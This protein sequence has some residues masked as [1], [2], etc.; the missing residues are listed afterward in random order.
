VNS[1]S[2]KIANIKSDE[3]F[4]IVEIDVS[5]VSLKSII[6]ETPETVPFLKIGSPMNIMFKETEVS[7]AKD[8]SG[9]LSLQNKIPCLIKDIERGKLLSKIFLD[10]KGNKIISIITTGAVEQLDLKIDDEVLALIK[11]NEVMLAPL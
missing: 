6:I 3:Y 5:G 11:T 8:F 2:G 9:K 1:L 4:S 10:C 7:I